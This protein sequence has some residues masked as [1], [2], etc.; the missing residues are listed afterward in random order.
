M[1]EDKSNIV[2]EGECG[3]QIKDVVEYED[4]VTITW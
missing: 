4:E 3:Y 1:I 2:T